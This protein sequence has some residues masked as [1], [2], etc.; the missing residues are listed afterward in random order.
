MKVLTLGTFDI[1]HYGHFRFLKRCR[2]IAGDSG[3]VIVGLNTDDFILR[4]RKQPPVMKYKDREANLLEL[5]WIDEVWPN[6][7]PNYSARRLIERCKPDMLVIST[8]WSPWSKGKKDYLKQLGIT[9]EFLDK[10]LI[11][12]AFVP[13]TRG[14]SSSDIKSSVREKVL[15]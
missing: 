12:L 13:H 5:P 4:Y 6:N 15:Q 1:I 10:N 3:E 2:M 11:A 9:Q 14:I 8:D 7:Q